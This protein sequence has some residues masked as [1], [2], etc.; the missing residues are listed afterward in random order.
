MFVRVIPE[1]VIDE[2]PFL[3]FLPIILSPTS[4]RISLFNFLEP[5]FFD[6]FAIEF[7]NGISSLAGRL[8]KSGEINSLGGININPPDRTISDN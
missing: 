8:N 5:I 1:P 3:I 6:V 4:T 2:I 7:I